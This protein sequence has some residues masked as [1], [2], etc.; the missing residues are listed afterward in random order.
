MDAQNER[1]PPVIDHGGQ[2]HQ[3]EAN[4]NCSF[5]RQDED[6]RQAADGWLVS[7]TVHM[8][9]GA[10]YIG[11]WVEQQRIH[12]ST[13]VV[14]YHRYA[15]RDTNAARSAAA[16][17]AFAATGRLARKRNSNAL[18]HTHA[19]RFTSA[20]AASKTGCEFACALDRHGIELTSI[21]EPRPSTLGWLDTHAWVDKPSGQERRRRR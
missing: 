17:R 6:D 16:Y 14:E 8:L 2:A 7:T 1:P 18:V 19:A 4:I 11:T 15:R 3:E 13:H 10:T 20:G 9:V 12:P 5:L 21:I